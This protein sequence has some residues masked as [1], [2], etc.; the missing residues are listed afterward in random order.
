MP[1]QTFKLSFPTPPSVNT[2]FR[3]AG[4]G[5][6]VKHRIKSAAY[7]KWEKAAMAEI[8]IQRPPKFEGP[9]T[10]TLWRGE[11]RRNADVSNYI[12]AVED[13]LV[14]MNI[15]EG[16]TRETVR[17]VSSGYNPDLEGSVVI[18]QKVDV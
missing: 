5:D 7:T 1:G 6:R 11:L 17:R 15:I 3:N 13:V 2:L 8:M 14:K 9:V 4:A 16:D 10:L 12:K 18:I